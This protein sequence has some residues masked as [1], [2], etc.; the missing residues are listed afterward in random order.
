MLQ[1]DRHN[2][3]LEQLKKNK[4]IK[5]SDLCERFNISRQ[6][7]RKDLD[8]LE[9][10]NKLKK[11]HGGAILEKTANEPSFEDRNSFNLYQKKL[12]ARKA[13]EFIN[14]GDTIF[15]DMGTTVNQMLPFLVEIEK[16]TV[17]TSSIYVAYHLGNY[18]HIRILVSGGEMRNLEHSLSGS[19]ALQHFE[20]YFVDKAFLG[21]GG[22]TKEAGYT[23]YHIEEAE[24]RRLMIQQASKTYALMDSSKFGTVAFTQFAKAEDIDIMVTDN[25]ISRD[26]RDLF[27]VNGIHV[28]TVE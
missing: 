16:L 12:I 26:Y 7:A 15:L 27:K 9:K 21:I 11:V 8:T 23:D 25:N 18:P 24:I 28:E 10:E 13:V 6:T 22:F 17:I 19:A 20:H 2:Y 14:S 4:S 1:V 5:I 3:I